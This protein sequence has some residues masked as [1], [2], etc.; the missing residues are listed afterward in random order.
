MMSWV[1]TVIAPHLLVHLELGCELKVIFIVIFTFIF[2]LLLMKSAA[3]AAFELRRSQDV[4]RRAPI[5]ISGKR[6]GDLSRRCP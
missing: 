2:V 4:P 3:G 6:G 1:V 5:S